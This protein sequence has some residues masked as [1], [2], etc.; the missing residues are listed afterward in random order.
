M[1]FR[2]G[3]GLAP[4]LWVPAADAVN[5][6]VAAVRN[7]TIPTRLPLSSAVLEEDFVPENP[8]ARAAQQK[9]RFALV[10]AFFAAGGV[11]W[12]YAVR[13]KPR[14]VASLGIVWI[15]FGVL[16][17]GSDVRNPVGSGFLLVGVLYLVWGGYNLWSARRNR[18]QEA[19]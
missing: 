15:L 16:W 5:Y 18:G 9:I 7:G 11:V 12:A 2:E 1:E 3:V 10:V 6:A 17:I 4:D 19:A 8:W 14:T 13:K